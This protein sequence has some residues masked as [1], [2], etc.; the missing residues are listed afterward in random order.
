MMV[1]F[2]ILVERLSVHESTTIAALC[3]NV[4]KQ[5]NIKQCTLIGLTHMASN[6]FLRILCEASWLQLRK[7][8]IFV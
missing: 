2:D 1:P 5:Y 7:N 6:M 4:H 8:S 3:E